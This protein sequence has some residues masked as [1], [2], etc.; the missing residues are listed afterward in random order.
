MNRI[1][2]AR[3]FFTFTTFSRANVLLK[4]LQLPQLLIDQLVDS[5][6]K[7]EKNGKFGHK[8]PAI[9]FKQIIAVKAQNPS[10]TTSISCVT[11]TASIPHLVEEYSFTSLFI[12]EFKRI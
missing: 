3:L 4:K 9:T 2:K 10:M 8:N 6:S 1:S 5:E 11:R 7:Q 12:L